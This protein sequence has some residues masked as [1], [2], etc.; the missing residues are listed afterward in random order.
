[1]ERIKEKIRDREDKMSI[2]TNHKII[3]NILSKNSD[4]KDIE[5]GYQST[6]KNKPYGNMRYDREDYYYHIINLV[7]TNDLNK[8]VKKYK[9]YIND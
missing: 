2:N 8:W 3:K 5:K 4:I 7:N 1:M 9:L 6:K